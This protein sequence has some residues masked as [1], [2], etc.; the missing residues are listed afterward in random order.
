[1]ANKSDRCDA[2]E[3]GDLDASNEEALDGILG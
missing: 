2:R 3:S 1:M